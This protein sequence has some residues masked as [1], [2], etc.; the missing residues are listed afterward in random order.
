MP[1]GQF[2]QQQEPVVASRPPPHTAV[3][4]NQ[5]MPGQGGHGAYPQD[6]R[7]FS[8]GLCGCCTDLGSCCYAWWCFPCFACSTA[9]RM[10]E[11]CCCGCGAGCCLAPVSWVAMRT[12]LRTMFG[13]RGSICGDCLATACCPNLAMCQMNRE[14]KNRGL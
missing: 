8:T 11:D 3:I 4:V 5:V 1:E 14:L 6:I 12:K 9:S 10:G 2:Q 13:I 7:E